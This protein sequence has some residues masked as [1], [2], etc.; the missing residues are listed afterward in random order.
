LLCAMTRLL[1]RLARKGPIR[2]RQVWLQRAIDMGWAY[3]YTDKPSDVF[4][5]LPIIAPPAK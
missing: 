5:V 1:P 2:L 3:E 4:S